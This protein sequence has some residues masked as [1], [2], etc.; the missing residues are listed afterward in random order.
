MS[1][2]AAKELQLGMDKSI[3]KKILSAKGP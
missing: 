2:E 3:E 1:D